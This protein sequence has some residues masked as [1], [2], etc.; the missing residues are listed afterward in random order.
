MAE[1]ERL[2]KLSSIVFPFCRIIS[3]NSAGFFL[4]FLQN[5]F[6]QFCRVIDSFKI[7]IAFKNLALFETWQFVPNSSKEMVTIV[8]KP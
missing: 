1:E 3:F 4:S 7:A 8:L 6:F 2:F 5:Y